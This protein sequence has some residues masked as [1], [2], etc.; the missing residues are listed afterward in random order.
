MFVPVCA[1]LDYEPNIV[2]FFGTVERVQ[3][4]RHRRDLGLPEEFSS[5]RFR[6][7]GARPSRM[8]EARF[9]RS[10]GSRSLVV[11]MLRFSCEMRGLECLLLGS[12]GQRNLVLHIDYVIGMNKAVG[13][14]AAIRFAEGFYAA[15][16]AGRPYDLAFKF[17]LIPRSICEA[18][19]STSL[20]Y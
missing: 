8:R 16:L 7:N 20:R 19:P 18:P 11:R 1:L 15:L 17:E 9:C 10:Q 13:D 14:E 4:R 12:P 3:Q 2:H 5:E 6:Q